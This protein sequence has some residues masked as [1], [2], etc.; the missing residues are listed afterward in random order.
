MAGVRVADR[1]LRCGGSA[2]T[3]RTTM[4]AISRAFACLFP[5]PHQIEAP[6]DR[7]SS[8][9]HTPA[10]PRRV[11]CPSER[12]VGRASSGLRAEPKADRQ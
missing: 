8:V 2:T 9:P 6:A 4:L 7:R 5:A 12:T 11:N 1:L 10:L 3:I